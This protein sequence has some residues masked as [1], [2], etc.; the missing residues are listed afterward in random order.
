M[1]VL[2]M[3]GYD[4]RAE[5]FERGADAFLE[6]PYRPQDVFR[7]VERAISAERERPTHAA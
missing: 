5:A 6:K 7:E 4:L 1:R 3:S 2:M